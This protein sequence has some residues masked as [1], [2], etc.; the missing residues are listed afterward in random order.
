VLLEA[1]MDNKVSMPSIPGLSS[2]DINKII[3]LINQLI[4]GPPKQENRLSAFLKIDG[5]EGESHHD[6]HKGEIEILDYHWSVAQPSAASASS[7]GTQTTE[8]AHFGD[9]IV[10]KGLDKASPSLAQACASGT[11]LPKAILTICR[12]SDGT[13]PFMIYTLLDVIITSIRA[14]ARGYG[15]SLPLEELSLSYG[16]IE[17]EYLQIKPEGGSP[18]GRI[19]KSWNLKTNK[20]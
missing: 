11:H 15:E 13:Q 18:Q 4:S 1:I 2:I 10:Y 3:G 5:I 20:E 17:W 12:A 8:R 6:K 14:G 19:K 7:A 9:L 16:K